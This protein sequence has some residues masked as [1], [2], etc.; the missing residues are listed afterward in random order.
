MFDFLKTPRN[1]KVL[2]TS[3]LVDGRLNRVV[4]T[5]F[6][7]GELLVPQFVLDE[8]QALADSQNEEK[9]KKGKRGLIN[10][11]SIQ[12][13]VPIQIETKFSDEVGKTKE[14][15]TKLVMFCKEKNCKLVTLDSNLNK[16]A[17]IHGVVVLNI[18]ELFLAL[19]PEY[20]LGDKITVK[21]AK[22]GNMPGQGVGGLEDGTMVVIDGAEGFI[23]QRVTGLIRQVS[24]TPSGLMY[25]AKIF[26][27]PAQITQKQ[28]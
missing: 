25:F 24:K 14:V 18:N 10:L 17:K 23:G 12:K 4:E 15:D 13:L 26:K 5:G 9:R 28:N 8:L 11:E 2:D 22:A 21:I 7:E 27:Q 3:V 16:I 20:T 6:V 19:C 1:I